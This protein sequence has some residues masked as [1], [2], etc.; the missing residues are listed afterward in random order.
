MALPRACPRCRTRRSPRGVV[1]AA[2]VALLLAVAVVLLAVPPVGVAAAGGGGG[3]G[4]GGSPA[5]EAAKQLDEA[6][7]GS[8]GAPGA[9]GDDNTTADGV[10][11]GGGGDGDDDAAA[12]ANDAAEDDGGGGGPG[13]GNDGEPGIDD[14]TTDVDAKISQLDAS[15]S[16][17]NA[18]IH[19]QQ[20]ALEQKVHIL[21]KVHLLRAELATKAHIIKT[22]KYEAHSAKL[23]VDVAK[24]RRDSAAYQVD[25]TAKLRA[26]E[27]QKLEA[28][29]KELPQYHKRLGQLKEV[30]VENGQMAQQLEHNITELTE[31]YVQLVLQFKDRGMTNWVEMQAKQLPPLVQGTLIKTTHALGP[32]FEGFEEASNLNARVVEEVKERVQTY[33]PLIKSSPFYGGILFYIIILFP[34]V[35][36]V[37]AAMKLNSH[38]KTMTISHYLVLSNLYFGVLSLLCLFMSYLSGADVLLVFHHRNESLEGT[39]VVLHGL[40]YLLH[41][42]LHFLSALTRRDGR[43]VAQFL[44]MF[45]VG[46]HYFL[47]VYARA[48]LNEDPVMDLR[49]YVLYAAIFIFTLYVRC[50]ML[51]PAKRK[52]P[53][54]ASTSSTMSA[55]NA[56]LDNLA[57]GTSSSHEQ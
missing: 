57:V 54:L 19:A 8:G 56:L 20:A 45:I 6:N 55:S 22:H 51:L 47:H 33:M 18:N 7:S 12:G 31:Q 21:K 14:T 5:S 35:L 42:A 39:F 53:L 13:G 25:F 17:A 28:L 36:F 16:K 44:S 43:E 24:E 27:S 49:A 29:R 23:D 48:V 10:D 4:K 11:G 2:G 1:V 52:G 50:T 15:V 41:L 26:D 30:A 32:L 3:E 9:D 34:M 46:T 38:L 37:S 40:F